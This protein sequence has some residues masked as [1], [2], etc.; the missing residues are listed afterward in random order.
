MRIIYWLLRA[1]E[2]KN[3][4]HIFANSSMYRLI[5]YRSVRCEKEAY[6]IESSATRLITGFKYWRYISKSRLRESRTSVYMASSASA[7]ALFTFFLG[8]VS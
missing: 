3:G 5:F 8:F 7:A 1:I 4:C 2:S 6:V